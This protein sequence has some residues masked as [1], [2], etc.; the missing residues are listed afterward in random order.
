MAKQEYL[1]SKIEEWVEDGL[2]SPEQAEALRQREAEGAAISPARRVKADEIFVYLGSLVVFLAL[3]FLVGLNWGELESAGR[4]LSLLVPTVVM[5]ALGWRL[6]G[7]ESAEEARRL[8]LRRGAE[9]LWL[10]ACLLS[11]LFFV[12]TFYELGLI[13]LSERGP[14]DPWVVLSCL[15]A[16]G[17]AAVAFVLLPTITQSIAFHLCGSAVLLTFLGWLDYTLPPLDHFL[18]NLLIL[19]IGLVAGGLCLALSEWLR[20]EERKDLVGVSRIFGTLAILGFTFILAMDEYP[21]TWQK[22]TMEA[23][24]FLASIAFIAASVQRQSEAFLY[25]GAAYLFFLIIYV[26]FEHFAD[27]IGMPIAL[28]IIGG[29]LIGLGLGTERLSRRI[30]APT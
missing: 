25:S 15:L 21:A 14:A 5:L 10:G 26:N 27:R 20:A 8:R 7:S 6:R 12:V 2:I 16:T 29:L 11:V 18:E 3:A 4:I 28:L 9:A 23:I 22:A 13:D 24:A 1:L 19:V 30:R 17:V